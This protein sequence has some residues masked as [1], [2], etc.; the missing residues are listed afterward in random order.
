MVDNGQSEQD[1]VFA[2]KRRKLL[3]S[4]ARYVIT[5][6]GVFIILSILAILYFIA[7]EVYPLSKS[8]SAKQSSSISAA[9]TST[10]LH[11]GLNDRAEVAFTLDDTGLLRVLSLDKG[12]VLHERSIAN[13]IGSGIAAVSS[14]L[15]GRKLVLGTRQGKVI[16]L[17]VGIRQSE[18]GL[19]VNLEFADAF[20]F[21]GAS[22]ES[23]TYAKPSE[24][25][26]AAAAITTDKKL[27]YIERRAQGSLLEDTPPSNFQVELTHLL[28]GDSPTA[29]AIDS[30][31]ENLYVGTAQGHLF[32][33]SLPKNS[34]PVPVAS[35]AVTPRDATPI[36]ALGFLVG[37]RSLLVG[38]SAGEVS[39]WFQ[40][41]DKE[42]VTSRT[43]MKAHEMQS[44]LA[45]ITAFAAS[46]RNRGFISAD[47]NGTVMLHHA[48]SER[49]LLNMKASQSSIKTLVLSPKSDTALLLDDKGAMSLWSIDNPH[50]ETSIK[51]LFAKVWYEGYSGPAYVWQ[52]TGMDDDF[53]PKLSLTPLAFGTLKG[54]LYAMLFAVPLAIM[55]ALSASQFMHPN[56]KG[57]VKP[58]VEI[59]AAM[60]SVVLGFLGGLWLAPIMET[61]VPGI[62]ISIPILII[63]TF[64]SVFTWRL[65]PHDFKRRFREGTE[66]LML[67]PVYA[68]GIYLSLALS[69]PF[70]QLFLGGDFRTWLYGSA[71]VP[72]DQRNSM[73]VGFVMGFAVVPLI[74]T[75]S[76]DALSNVPRHLISGSLAL[77]ANKWQTALRIVLPTASPGIFSA[78]MIG[79]GR[80]VG[81]TMIVLMATGNTPIMDWN[82]FNG[83]RALSANIAVE[84]P[85]A[86][87]GETLYRVLFLA[88][89][90][91]FVLT[92]F[93]NTA[94][95]MIRMQLRKKYGKL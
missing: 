69:G 53:E 83:F 28:K 14:D 11:A 54:T 76:E 40:V 92:F 13:D 37:G 44:H 31:Q 5:F 30:F 8:A 52:S 2:S 80:A 70:E 63:L 64:A 48:T 90:L 51:T 22:L 36:R 29:L 17:E 16:P 57:V 3:D 4:A 77:G 66:I 35:H 60:P 61:R 39:V 55:G 41:E 42:S 95:E 86:P 49:M 26:S 58:V 6:G 67:I 45:P 34:S 93:I 18:D 88:A 94:A 81:E 38:T 32:H 50:P 87:H 24:Q 56:L 33:I 19:E 91:L 59:M 62:A 46:A 10:I 84:I 75:I 27:I 74:F 47:S 73:V 21:A 7:L 65:A 43:L 23:V 79:L 71:G 25:R 85:E 82:L 20:D 9:S 72:Y 78:I 15:T 1:K 89:L 68:A 12:S